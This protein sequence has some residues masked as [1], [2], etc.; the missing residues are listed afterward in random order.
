MAS[1]PS[2][3]SEPSAYE[4]A[5]PVVAAN[6]AKLERA[7]GRTRASHAGQSYAEVHRALIEALVQEGVRHVVPS[8]VVEEWA[9]RVSGTGGTG[10]GAD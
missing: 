5:V 3:P 7:V 6:L 8:Q 4:K 10:D 9:R 1:E 2:E